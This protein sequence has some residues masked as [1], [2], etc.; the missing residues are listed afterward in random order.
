MEAVSE[1]SPLPATADSDK[2]QRWPRQMEFSYRDPNSTA[3]L[4]SKRTVVNSVTGAYLF[5]PELS[6]PSWNIKIFQDGVNLLVDPVS[7]SVIGFSDDI[8]SRAISLDKLVTPDKEISKSVALSRAGKYLELTGMETDEYQLESIKL[9]ELKVDPSPN[10]RRWSL[11]YNRYS[12]GVPFNRQELYVELDADKGRLLELSCR[13]GLEL[14]SVNRVRIDKQKAVAVA[15]AYVENQGEPAENIPS[16]SIQIVQPDAGEISDNGEN[17]GYD[18]KTVLAWMVKLPI[19]GA[20]GLRQ[21]YEVAI[22]AATGAIIHAKRSSAL[23]DIAS[24]ELSASQAMVVNLSQAKEIQFQLPEKVDTEKW[25][26]CEANARHYYGSLAVVRAM[27]EP[28][29]AANPLTDRPVKL[30]LKMANGKVLDYSF[31][32]L[33]FVIADGKGNY[34]QTGSAFQKLMDLQK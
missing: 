4:T 18:R 32:S 29:T 31:Y 3:I 5:R 2:S 6:R 16:V 24:A 20:G 34:L 17:V 10:E 8:V 27:S 9:R 1:L 19:T 30:R 26:D 12:N 11:V 25:I 15:K 14:P 7:N 21:S 28:P 33:S 22:S 13:N 23:V